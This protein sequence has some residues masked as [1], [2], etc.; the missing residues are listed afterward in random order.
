MSE[1]RF[2][3][4]HMEKLD[5]PERRKALPP[6]KILATLEIRANDIVLDLGAGTGYFTLPA[7]RLTSGKVYALDVEPKMLEVLEQRVKEQ[8]FN[9]VELVEG[10]IEDIPMENN[11]VDRIIASFVLHEVD[12]LSKGI[13][14]IR[15]VL[16]SGGRCLCIEWKKKPTEQGPPLAHRIHSDDMKKAFEENGF[17]IVHFAYPTEAHY[18]IVAQK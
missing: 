3:P 16:K 17:Q 14:E 11:Q 15:R 7:A 13:R 6:E 8:Q 12:P 9:H 4:S 18:I 2:D 10:K 5:N 1:R